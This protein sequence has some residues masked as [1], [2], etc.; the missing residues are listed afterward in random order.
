MVARPQSNDDGTWMNEHF[1]YLSE[2]RSR[3]F[4]ML[5]LMMAQCQELYQVGTATLEGSVQCR[6]T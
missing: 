6:E 3:E 2:V 5:P 1:E 4:V